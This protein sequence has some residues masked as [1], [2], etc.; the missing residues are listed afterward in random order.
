MFQKEGILHEDFTRRLASVLI[1]SVARSLESSSSG[2][3]YIVLSQQR[4]FEIVFSD[5]RTQVQQ[6][7][8]RNSILLQIAQVVGSNM[9][10]EDVISFAARNDELYRPV[11]A[12]LMDEIH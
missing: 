7:T 1:I 8:M 12:P 2:G 9:W 4:S 3:Q 6:L 11:L 10:N 5:H